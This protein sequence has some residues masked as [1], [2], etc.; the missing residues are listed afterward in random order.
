MVGAR[1]FIFLP[2]LLDITMKPIALYSEQE[3]MLK[4]SLYEWTLNRVVSRQELEY[5]V[6]LS[7]FSLRSL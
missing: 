3:I 7:S 6:A 1:P 5:Q 2:V 4:N